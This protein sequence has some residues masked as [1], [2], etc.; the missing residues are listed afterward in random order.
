ML[1][2]TLGMIV[3]GWFFWSFAGGTL[4]ELA[5]EGSLVAR[6]NPVEVV[7]AR[8][9]PAGALGPFHGFG[10]SLVTR[11]NGVERIILHGPFVV[12]GSDELPA[13]T[14]P[15]TAA[16]DPESG[17]LTTSIE[18]SAFRGRALA[19]GAFALFFGLPIVTLFA[20][21]ISRARDHLAVL[22]AARASEEQLVEVEQVAGQSIDYRLTSRLAGG[23]GGYRASAAPRRWL[24]RYRQRTD[25]RTPWT[26]GSR[27]LVLLPPGEKTG[28]VVRDDGWPFLIEGEERRRMRDRAEVASAV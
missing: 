20:A 6:A 4:V 25:E 2:V 16:R 13:S 10:V 14:S 26:L 23:E 19:V 24:A 8:A 7:E 12:L 9:V 27:I 28:V 3:G 22:R 5:S 18:R 11:E 15:A 17:T 21:L 1:A